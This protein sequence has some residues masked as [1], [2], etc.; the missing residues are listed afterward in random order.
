MKLRDIHLRDPFV[1]AENGVYYLY[2]TRRGPATNV[3]PNERPGLFK[4]TETDDGFEI[5]ECVET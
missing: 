2:G 1:F 5:V 3:N 4:V